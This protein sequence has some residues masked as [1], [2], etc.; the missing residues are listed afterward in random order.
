GTYNVLVTK[1]GYRPWQRTIGVTG[2]DVQRFDYPFLFP[3][4]LRT[5][6]VTTIEG[7]AS[8]AT[9]SP[10]KRWL[11]VGEGVPMT[12][13]RVYDIKNPAKPTSTTV[14]LSPTIVTPGEQSHAW[15]AVEWSD[16]NR[17]VLLS[18]AF[19]SA[20]NAAQEYILF[21]RQTATPRNLTRELS[22]AP[23]D[24]LRLFDK[25]PN[26]FFIL[27]S[28]T[29]VLRTISLSGEPPVALPI[30]HVLAY[31][32]YNDD[33]VLYA[34]DTLLDGTV[35]T[36]TVAVVLQQAGRTVELRRFP[37]GASSYL[38][39]IAQF[40]GNWYAF[41]GT[42]MS[43]GVHVFRNP[44]EAQLATPSK[45]PTAFRFLKM[46]QP[47]YASFSTN[48]QFI[49]VTNGQNHRVYDIE[50]DNFYAYQTAPPIDTPQQHPVWMDGDRLLYTSGG[51]LYVYDYDNLNAQQLQQA[52]PDFPVFFDAEYGH[53]FSLQRS[54][55]AV[56]LTVTPLTSEI[57]R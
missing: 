43:K 3:K 19:T 35:L 4:N 41:A 31:K 55:D 20:G 8:F 21:D 57:Q 26:Q 9:Q 37:A 28:Q 15:F 2:G 5:S 12:R 51:R 29:K 1:D 44:F 45:K 17:H 50:Y 14:I 13:V 39:D 33:T 42:N 6:L 56:Q 54:Q 38:L 36:G 40:A 11:I 46:P 25:R 24:E 16:N 30:Q 23:T 18:H 7:G 34:T 52:L 10:D 27:S 32:S 48:T 53:M 22:L 47:T 49:A